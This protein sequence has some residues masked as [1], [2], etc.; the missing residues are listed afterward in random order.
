MRVS[1]S[2][3]K[4]WFA[5]KDYERPNQNMLNSAWQS[6]MFNSDELTGRSSRV[7]YL[8]DTKDGWI[9]YSV[10]SGVFVIRSNGGIFDYNSLTNRINVIVGFYNKDNMLIKSTTMRFRVWFSAGYFAHCISA[11]N[12]K[13]IK[14]FLTLNS[15]GYIRMVTKKFN[16]GNFDLKVP[17]IF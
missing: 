17:C 11:D 9:G 1:K 12:N 5:I 10:D 3:K 6:L 2:E 14:D 7:M 13:M 16:S 15:D 4:D 8:Y